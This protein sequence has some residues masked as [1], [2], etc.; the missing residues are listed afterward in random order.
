MRFQITGQG[1]PL[2]G[3]AA[4][5]PNGTIIDSTSNDFFSVWARGLTPPINC[6]ALDDEARAA[7][8]AEAARINRGGI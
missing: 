2:Q 5:A 3:G 4:L 6:I 7:C 1:W 8:A